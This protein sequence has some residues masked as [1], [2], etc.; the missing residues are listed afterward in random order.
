[1]GKH[2]RLFELADFCLVSEQYGTKNT[3]K[4]PK[5]AKN[6]ENNDEK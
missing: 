4:V 6:D 5:T 2:P 3:K 1:L